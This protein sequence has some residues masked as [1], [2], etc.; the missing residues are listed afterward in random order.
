MLANFKSRTFF[1]QFL[2]APVQVETLF[3]NN[4]IALA[5]LK[6]IQK[7][8]K[9]GTNAMANPIPHNAKSVDN[10]KAKKNIST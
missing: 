1:F 3:K 8:C 4:Q 5:S 7:K 2:I 10:I 9:I 6:G